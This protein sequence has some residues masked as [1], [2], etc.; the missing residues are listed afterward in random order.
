MPLTIEQDGQQV[1]VYT[2]DDLAAKTQEAADEVRKTLEDEAAKTAAKAAPTSADLAA[3]RRSAET[4]MKEQQ[5]TSAATIADLEGKLTTAQ[6]DSSTRITELEGQLTESGKTAAELATIRK[7]LDAEKVAKAETS[8][9]IATLRTEHAQDL[10]LIELK[11]EPAKLVKIKALLAADAVD[12]TD[13]AALIVALDVLRDEAPGLFSDHA[14]PYRG[15][16][17]SQRPPSRTGALTPT[18]AGNLPQSEYEQAR[19]DGNIAF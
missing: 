5:A 2:A 9:Q 14:A 3:A 11:V 12:V 16:S 4:R 17:G 13:E 10:K 7:E 8:Q 18:Q 1:V 15:S 19:R 6:T